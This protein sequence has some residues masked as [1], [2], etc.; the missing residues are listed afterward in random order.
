MTWT[1]NPGDWDIVKH[2]P[3]VLDDS[4]LA[5][6]IYFVLDHYGLALADIRFVLDGYSPQMVNIQVPLDY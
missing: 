2:L 4:H 6:D 5:V 1:R 3:A